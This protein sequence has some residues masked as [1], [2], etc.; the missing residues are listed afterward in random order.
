[1]GRKRLPNGRA[2]RISPGC[3]NLTHGIKL[4]K[5]THILVNSV[6][7]VDFSI[8]NWPDRM[9][10]SCQLVS[11]LVTLSTS[12]HP[13]SSLSS[14]RWP[15]VLVLGF[16][17]LGRRPLAVTWINHPASSMSAFR[18]F[19]FSETWREIIFNHDF[20]SLFDWITINT[21]T[22]RKVVESSFCVQKIY[23]FRSKSW[24]YFLLSILKMD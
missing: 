1:M 5:A 13:L 3:L 21:I 23:I 12:R 2:R 4:T 9:R 10:A 16:W 17:A 11:S 14:R 20:I 18:H 8:P 19:P 22:Q 7:W 6:N 15:G 24:L